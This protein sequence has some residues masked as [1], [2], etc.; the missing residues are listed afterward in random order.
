MFREKQLFVQSIKEF[1][2][3]W[4]R[5][6]PTSFTSKL[7]VFSFLCRPQA[8]S[9]LSRSS[10]EFVTHF[11]PTKDTSAWGYRANLLP[12]Y[13]F[14]GEQPQNVPPGIFFTIRTGLPTWEQIGS[15]KTL[16]LTIN[17]GHPMM[18]SSLI[19][20]NHFLGYPEYFCISRIHSKWCYKICIC[21][22]I[23]GELECFRNYKGLSITFP[24]ISDAMW[25]ITKWDIFWFLDSPSH[26]WIRKFRVSFFPKKNGLPWEVKCESIKLQNISKNLLDKLRK[27]YINGTVI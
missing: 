19:D 15:N 1:E 14:Y 3:I 17:Q 11:F 13:E 5:N 16:K 25:R 7:C 2:G 20:W 23:L 22:V 4:N 10:K 24:K 21:F 12:F 18:V 27:L 8:N 9:L 6:W 26:F